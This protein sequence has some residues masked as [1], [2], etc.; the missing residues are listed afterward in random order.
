MSENKQTTKADVLANSQSTPTDEQVGRVNALVQYPRISEPEPAVTVN[1]GEQQIRLPI[2]RETK[3][4]KTTVV[5]GKIDGFF[6]SNPRSLRLK[7]I[8]PVLSA[9]AKLGVKQAD[10]SAVDSH[11]FNRNVRD[12]FHKAM[13]FAA[14]EAIQ[15][16]V[17]VSLQL[18]NRTEKD[19][20][21]VLTSKHGFEY[22]T[23]APDKVAIEQSAANKSKRTARRQTRKEKRDRINNPVIPPS[24]RIDA[25]TTVVLPKSN[26]APAVTPATEPATK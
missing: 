26:G 2:G 17:P 21:K 6:F 19:G 23:Q 25:T 20:S 22:R 16:G 13:K 11:W 1:Y 24:M 18:S 4:K 9:L 7:K 5:Y 12:V 14:R 3:G 8:K 15:H 10:G